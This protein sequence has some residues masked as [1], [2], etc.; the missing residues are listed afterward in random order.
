[1]NIENI[2]QE[3]S[4]RG[5]NSEGVRVVK[6]G[7][8][9]IGIRIIDSEDQS[10][11]PIIYYSE[12]ETMEEIF[13]KVREALTAKKPAMD[14][15]ILTDWSYVR[16]HVFISIQRHSNDYCAKKELLNLEVCARVYIN[17]TD[18]NYNGSYKMTQELLQKMD[19]SEEELWE[20][21][22]NNS[23][24]LY[25]V[26]SM[27]AM[28]GL[29]ET[30]DE[31]LYVVTADGISDGA[32]ALC[33][34][35]VFREFCKAHSEES[36]VILPSSTQEVIVLPGSTVESQMDLSTLCEMVYSINR[37]VVDPLI[38][39]DPVV[40]Q[41]SLETDAITIAAEHNRR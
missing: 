31:V 23:R 12:K 5:I 14:S 1:M 19:V 38:Q 34:P 8:E 9:C 10:I 39:L 27:S 6:N 30:Q 16:D 20:A 15:R 40:Y 18:S 33:F 13:G 35:E 25:S 4:K 28:L 29:K 7:V 41:Y 11:S 36:C 21:S 22:L 32:G 24:P 17:M 37:D 2:T 3:L 26:H